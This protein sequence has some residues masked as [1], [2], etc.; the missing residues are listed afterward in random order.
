MVRPLYLPTPYQDSAEAGRLILRDG[1]T[2]VLRVAR[3]DDRTAVH[4]FF[5]RLSPDSKWQRF[6]S[7]SVPEE[8]L[9]E[10]LCDDTDPRQRLTLIVTRAYGS[11]THIIATGSYIWMKD[12]M[13]EVAVTVDDSLH[14]KGI[15]ALL[16][17]RLALLAV[18]HGIV[19]FW[20]L[21]HADNQA[22]LEVFRRSGFHVNEK[23]SDGCVEADFLVVPTET[24][25]ARSEIRDRVFT[26]ASMRPFFQPASV[27]V[28]GASRNPYSIGYRILEALQS[29][30]FQGP[31]YPVNSKA[32]VVGSRRAYPSISQL[33]EAV[34]LA[35]IAVPRDEV[36]SVVEDAAAAGVKAVVVITAGFAEVNAEGRELQR[37]LVE[38]IRE[39]GMRMVGPNCMGIL[40]TDPAVQLNATFSAVF[41]PAGK[42]AM[43]SQSGALGMAILSYARRINLGLS[44]FVSVGNKTD[45]SG[46]DLLQYWEEDVGTD[47]ILLYLES[48]GNPR[49]FARIARRVSRVKPI[50]AVKGGR[51]RAGRRAA[52][53]HTAALAA[54]DVAVDALFRQTGVIRAETLVEMFDLAATLST[55][56]LPR[57]RRTAIVT[58]AGGPGILCADACE[59]GGLVVPEL[60][61]KTKSAL[62]KFLPKTAS[63]GNPIDMIASATPEHYHRSIETVLGAEEVDA[64]VVIYIPISPADS[65]SVIEG[66]R[67]GVAGS[68]QSGGQGKPVLT[69]LM[70]EEGVSMPLVL[71]HES[72][73][74]YAFPESAAGVLSKVSTY[75]EWREQPVGVIPDFADIHA[76]LA[77]ETCHRAIAERG[78]GW[79][80]AEETRA[81]L[82]AMGLPV[83]TCGVART[84]EE[85]AELAQK[86]GFPVAVKLASH[87]IVHKTEIGAV[88]LNLADK[89]AVRKAFHE[90]RNRVAE[91]NKLEAMEGV[92]VQPMITR[93]VEV[94]V[95]MTEDRL[96][97]PLV[98][99]G[100]GGIHVE[101]LGDV[102]FRITPLT[103]HDAKQMVRE[104]RGYRLLEGY[105]GHQPA[106]VAAIE[107]VLLR[108]S[109]LVEE[110]PEISEIDLNPIFALPPGEGCSIADARIR[111]EPLTEGQV[112]RYTTTPLGEISPTP[113][114]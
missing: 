76:E 42:V 69:C 55:Q 89:S 97:G 73:P 58:N 64:L 10:S 27:A 19:R 81:V 83:P 25:V 17:E 8:E 111:V 99:F 87:Q 31:I 28:V 62:S 32:G 105:R 66:I 47:V 2:A 61:S 14:G 30:R 114:R 21:T 43:S 113:P 67:N 52:G 22:M 45:V 110:I 35:V 33:P 36:L 56:P 5:S 88:R 90:I 85:A 49:R 108:V 3:P 18:R 38:R 112:D 103:D 54:S 1:T 4:E 29:N 51:T 12:R 23:I 48:F 100:L 86:I 39:R 77:R 7:M 72:V 65:P 16:L 24:S 79:L 92:L 98:A 78:A 107:E 96:F 57:G 82:M 11:S 59:A 6:F 104:I 75:A 95:G 101:I 109:R 15:G 50:V 44:T 34:D 37:K 46:N 40:N 94:M 70:A 91:E 68:R 60:S 53:S 26:T 13:A 74:T 63:V 9:V 71:K 20:A 80:T 102:Q 41:P 106:D 84:S 93:G